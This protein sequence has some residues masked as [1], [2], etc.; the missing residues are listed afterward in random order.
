M[1]TYF[2]SRKPGIRAFVFILLFF[3]MIA[4][5]QV[6]QEWAKTYSGAAKGMDEAHAIVTD[7]SG[8]IAI[9]GTSINANGD[10][11][12]VTIKYNSSG[13]LLWKQIYNGVGN[14]DDNGKAIAID[15]IGNVY[16]AGYA[17]GKGTG[18]DMVLLKYDK[19]GSP[20]W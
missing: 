8:N 7:A 9:T 11:D 2:F 5:G 18:E 4:I 1:R 15:A 10:L 12:I 16:V 6:S 19:D 14:D 20:L 3:P 17:T 13:N